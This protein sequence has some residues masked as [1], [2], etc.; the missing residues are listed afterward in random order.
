M[1]HEVKE[2]IYNKISSGEWKPNQKIP[3][4]EELIKI[5]GL[6][7]MTIRKAIDVLKEKEVLF[8]IQGKGVY[9]SPFHEHSRYVSLEEKLNAT[10]VETLPSTSEMPEK[11]LNIFGEDIRFDKS[12]T[13]AFVRL[14]FINSEIAAYSINWVNYRAINNAPIKLFNEKSLFKNKRFG[15]VISINKME[16]TTS[17]DKNLLLLKNEWIPTIYSYYLMK[18]RQ[19]SMA[20]I[21]K[22]KPKYFSSTE[23][24]TRR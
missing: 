19:I 18:D 11:L 4:E 9:L 22:I 23:F 2:F 12:A 8:S 15:K 5:L 7:K 13:E 21:V 16:K 17:T 6:S 10:H 3:T 1:D 20:R 24:K 14:Y